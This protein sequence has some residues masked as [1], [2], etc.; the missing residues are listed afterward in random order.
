MSKYK[1]RAIDGSIPSYS[2]IETPKGFISLHEECCPGM[3]IEV[4]NK[5][6][7]DARPN[8]EKKKFEVILTGTKN[9]K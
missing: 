1:T 2:N 3:P 8:F 7:N 4:A 6:F 5:I 9:D